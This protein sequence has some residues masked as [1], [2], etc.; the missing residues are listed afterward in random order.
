[1]G[2][3]FKA[4]SASIHCLK[5]KNEIVFNVTKNSSIF[6]FSS[7]AQNLASKLPPSPNIFT[8][9]KVA[10]HYVSNAV[11]KDLNFQLLETSPEKIFKYFKR[12]K[13]I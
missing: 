8:E 3:S 7:L 1:M 4:V 11:S 6:F 2:L 10:F 5:D 12:F 9:S 13:P